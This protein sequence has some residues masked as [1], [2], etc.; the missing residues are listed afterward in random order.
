[1]AHI[2]CTTFICLYFHILCI[3]PANYLKVKNQ[4]GPYNASEC[5]AEQIVKIKSLLQLIALFTSINMS[6]VF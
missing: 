4:T 5:F 2:E 6:H 1:M 3:D